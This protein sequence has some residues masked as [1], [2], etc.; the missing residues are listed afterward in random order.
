MRSLYLAMALLLPIT[1]NSGV[2]SDML[3]KCLFSATSERDKADVVRWIYAAISVHPSLAEVPRLS[4]SVREEFDKRLARLVQ[5]LTTEQ[6]ASEVKDALQYEGN[7]A[8][9]QAFGALGQH[10]TRSILDDASVKAAGAEFIQH[11]NKGKFEP[12]LQR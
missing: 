7:G 11:L 12:I 9:K 2:H 6:C 8:L 4:A 3:T 5:R 10:A 1:C